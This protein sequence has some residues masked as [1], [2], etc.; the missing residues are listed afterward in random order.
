MSPVPTLGGPRGGAPAG[1][2]GLRIPR[3]RILTRISELHPRLINTS[4][5]DWDDLLWRALLAGDQDDESERAELASVEREVAER[6]A[7]A[8]AGALSHSPEG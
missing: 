7:V 1:S 4:E 6:E 2:P 3:K 5:P 8:P